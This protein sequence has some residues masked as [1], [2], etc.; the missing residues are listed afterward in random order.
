[1]AAPN[2]LSFLPDDYLERKGRRRANAVCAALSVVVM[3]A[4]ASAFWLT[5]RAMREVEARAAEVDKDLR[6]RRQEHR[7]GQPMKAKQRQDRAPGR[8]GRVAGREGPAEQPAGGVHQLAAAGHV[9][10]GPVDGVADRAPAP[11]PAADARRQAEPP[12]GRR[13]RPPPAAPRR[14]STTCTSS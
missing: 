14:C 9:A 2:E 10:A 8:A 12:A 13:K 1:M 7:A 6:R 3:G 4:I 11:P 5:E